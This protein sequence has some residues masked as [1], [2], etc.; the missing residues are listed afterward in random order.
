MDNPQNL[1]ACYLCGVSDQEI[2]SIKVEYSNY[3]CELLGKNDIFLQNLPL[4]NAVEQISSWNNCFHC[5]RLISELNLVLT[6]QGELVEQ[7]K[8]RIKKGEEICKL[9]ILYWAKVLRNLLIFGSG[10]P[11]RIFV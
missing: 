10:N 9:W 8:K 4:H 3:I 6:K 7:I 2:V 11:W 1:G 5:L